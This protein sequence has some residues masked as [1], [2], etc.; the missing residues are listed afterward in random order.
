M[1]AWY[2]PHMAVSEEW[3]HQEANQ[4]GED[5]AERRALSLEAHCLLVED[6]NTR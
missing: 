1:V 2:T 3:G 6:D 4:A 5:A